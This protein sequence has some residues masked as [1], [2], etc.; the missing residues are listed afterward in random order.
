VR[1]QIGWLSDAI[2]DEGDIEDL[3]SDK[4]YQDFGPDV[5]ALLDYKADTEIHHAGGPV[6]RPIPVFIEWP[7]A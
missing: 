6:T 5:S 4:A 3:L 7:P 1:Y 2:Q